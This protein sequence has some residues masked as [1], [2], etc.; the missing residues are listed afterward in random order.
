M[1]EPLVV[2]RERCVGDSFCSA[3]FPVLWLFAVLPCLSYSLVWSVARS[4]QTESRESESETGTT[5]NESLASVGHVEP[6]QDTDK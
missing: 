4:V 2:T 3:S 1:N 5:P 6:A